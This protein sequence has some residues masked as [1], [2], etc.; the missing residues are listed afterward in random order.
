MGYSVRTAS[1][2]Y[3][4][5]LDWKTKEILAKELYDDSQEPAELKNRAD[6]PTLAE[7]QLEAATT[8]HAQLQKQAAKAQRQ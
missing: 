8:L 2:R 3:T 6:D 4:E 1:V 5:W 7:Q